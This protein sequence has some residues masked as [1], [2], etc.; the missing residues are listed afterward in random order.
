MLQNIDR[1][2][3]VC[4]FQAGVLWPVAPLSSTA[5]VY[6]CGGH[7]ACCC[8]YTAHCHTTKLQCEPHKWKKIPCLCVYLPAGGCFW[9]WYALYLTAAASAFF[10][11]L[12]PRQRQELCS[13]I[14]CSI[15]LSCII[16]F[17][18]LS[19]CPSVRECVCSAVP[20]V[21]LILAQCVWFLSLV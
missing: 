15:L 9:F 10:A 4:A 18:P 6:G 14:T 19:P 8:L 16:L 20:I 7:S 5:P 11:G 17:L 13:A 2:C 21:S 12:S 3:A 1:Y